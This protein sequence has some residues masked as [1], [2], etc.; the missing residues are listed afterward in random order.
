MP[1]DLLSLRASALSKRDGARAKF[2]W[3]RLADGFLSKSSADLQP[4]RE[5]CRAPSRLPSWFGGQR[6]H[7]DLHQSPDRSSK[8]RR[9]PWDRLSTTTTVVLLKVRDRRTAPRCDV[10]ASELCLDSGACPTSRVAH[11]DAG[12]TDLLQCGAGPRSRTPQRWVRVRV[13]LQSIGIRRRRGLQ[14]TRCVR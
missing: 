7:R 2:A 3:P 5:R 14:L 12:A 6:I 13:P 4:R 9:P 8:D 1:P 11:P 10:P